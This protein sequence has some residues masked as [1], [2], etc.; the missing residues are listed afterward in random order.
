VIAGYARQGSKAYSTLFWR[1][2]CD[3]GVALRFVLVPAFNY[4]ICG[5]LVCSYS[6]AKEDLCQLPSALLQ[7][8]LLASEMWFFCHGLDLYFTVNNPFSSYESRVWKYHLF[9]WGVALFITI[10]PYI[11]DTVGTVYGFWFISESDTNSSYPVCWIKIQAATYL[12]WPIFVLFFMPLAIVYLFCL[13]TVVLAYVRLRKGLTQSFLPRVKLLVTSISNIVVLMLFW[14]V[15]MLI[16]GMTYQLR[17]D[18][19]ASDRTFNILMFMIASK[20]F[21]SLVVAINQVEYHKKDETLSGIEGEDANAALREEVLSFATAGIKNT[22]I[23]E[24]ARGTSVFTRQPR[25]NSYR[26]TNTLVTPWF[27]FRLLFDHDG[28]GL[29]AVKD[30]LENNKRTIQSAEAG[31][32]A[33]EETRSLLNG[34]SDLSSRI[35]QRSTHTSNPSTT[36]NPLAPMGNSTERNKVSNDSTMSRE[37]GGSEIRME[38]DT[39]SFMMRHSDMVDVDAMKTTTTTEKQAWGARIVSGF[40]NLINAFE[41]DRVEF[42]ELQPYYFQQIRKAYGVSKELYAEEFSKSIKQRMT[43]GGASGAFFFFSKTDKFV[44]KSCTEEEMEVLVQNAQVYSEYMTGNIN[45]FICKIYGVYELRI[46]NEVLYFFVMNNLFLNED[47]LT[48]NEKYDLKGSWVARNSAPPRDGQTFSCTYCERKFVYRKK[49]RNNKRAAQI[50]QASYQRTQSM[51]SEDDLASGTGGTAAGVE[52]GKGHMSSGL[53]SWLATLFGHQNA[54]GS[55]GS[56]SGKV[57]STPDG[58]SNATHANSSNIQCSDS[59]ELHDLSTD[60][61]AN[62]AAAFSDRNNDRCPF[63]TGEHFPN[64]IMK[65]NDIKHKIRLTEFESLEVQNQ[66]RMDAEFL[67][68][69]GIM[70]Y[71]LLVGVHIAEYEVDQTQVDQCVEVAS[72]SPKSPLDSHLNHSSDNIA[73]EGS[74]PF[75]LGNKQRSLVRRTGTMSKRNVEISATTGYSISEIKLNVNTDKDLEIGDISK[76]QAGNS[77]NISEANRTSRDPST[78]LASEYKLTRKL[79]VHKIIG[80]DAYF[81]GIIDF[82]QRWNFSKRMERFFKIFFKGAD[83]EGLSAIEPIIYKE[84]FLRKIEDILEQETQVRSFYN[85]F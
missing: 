13:M 40:C 56:S 8:F 28:E 2:M 54:D 9:T 48:M 85:K 81:M 63:T 4:Y 70:D 36:V 39:T 38:S 46:Y 1:A 76:A 16:Y 73:D 10:F 25:L 34:Q 45:T 83:P 12:G 49:R 35:S 26:K 58:R 33:E 82:Q 20:A 21:S 51:T 15:A 42:K 52:V 75:G 69:L 62:G 67:T 11:S 53:A 32:V 19:Q 27:F 14:G 7:F 23:T 79:A 31:M 78:V 66:L 77:I 3:L 71:S 65:D 64:V 18:H 43:E 17:N 5:N 61:S 80:P 74:S 68:S 59:V 44:G 50:S 47:G 60:Y 57:P 72:N 30:M 6:D 29:R 84:R 37:H 22:A 24:A 55:G 41:N